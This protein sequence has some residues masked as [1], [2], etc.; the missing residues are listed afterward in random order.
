MAPQTR[1]KD[2]CVTRPIMY[3]NTTVPLEAAD[4]RRDT[5]PDHTHKWTVFVRD[6][7]GKDDLGY[8]IKRVVFKLH[9]TYPQPTRVI[10]QPPFE[11]TE[12][13]WGEFEIQIRILFASC[14][15][16]KQLVLHHHLKLHPYGP[17]FQKQLAA[18]EIELTAAGVPRAQA[19]QSILYDELVFTEPTEA[20]LELLTSRPGALLL[21]RSNPP[22][23]PFSYEL[24]LAEASK[25]LNATQSVETELLEIKNKIREL[26][27]E[28]TALQ[29]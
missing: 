3:G 26:E 28:K 14:A 19:V 9:D 17:E 23:F 2:I 16:E 18:G 25:V 8:V 5:P 27:A 15:G 20:M 21:K 7:S 13:G 10:E 29:W 6:P 1:V 11:L 22:F 4:R 24:E 12:T